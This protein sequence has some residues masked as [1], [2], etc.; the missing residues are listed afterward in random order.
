MLNMG[1]I[2]W[3]YEYKDTGSFYKISEERLELDNKILS[4]EI[5]KNQLKKLIKNN[6]RTTYVKG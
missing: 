5:S 3:Q 1:E 6:L 4:G 2:T